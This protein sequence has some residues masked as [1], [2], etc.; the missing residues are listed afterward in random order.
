M[1]IYKA[2]SPRFFRLFK[3]SGW[4]FVGQVSSIAG[5]IIL[6]MILTPRL[7]PSQYGLLAIGMTFANLIIQVVMGPLSS[8]AGRFYSIAERKK[9]LIGYLYA[10]KKMVAY[11]TYII[12]VVGILLFFWLSSIEESQWA[13]LVISAFVF[14]A[15]SAYNSIINSIHNAARKREIV[16]LHISLE[17]WLKII[18]ALV[19]I[20]L[21]GVSGVVVIAG[22]TIAA[23]CTL[24]SQSIFLHRL[25]LKHKGNR[26]NID[27]WI[28]KI[29]IYSWPF[30]IWGIFGWLQQSS[31]RWALEFFEDSHEVGLFAVVTQLGYMPMV[32]LASMMTTFIS[33]IFFSMI[34]GATDKNSKENVINL[35]RKTVYFGFL[36][37]ACAV[38]ISSFSHEYIFQLFVNEDYWMASHF[39]PY[40]VLAGGVFSIAQLYASKMMAFMLTDKLMF[41]SIGSSI[42]GIFSAY[43]GVYFYSTFGAVLSLLVHAI[44]YYLLLLLSVK[45]H[46]RGI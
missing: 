4:V 30:A 34:G 9:D 28:K 11:A 15:L 41:A 13:W 14:A 7:N 42:I 31:T 3:E 22:Y 43:L 33:P 38:A 23:L 25:A 5:A 12:I 32:I 26:I 27:P 44:S 40:V 1:K 39:L 24:A 21:F 6:V 10:I 37:I 17:S 16:A 45:R 46:I 35:V 18:F 36:I 19:T 8:G 2:I 29:W 20:T